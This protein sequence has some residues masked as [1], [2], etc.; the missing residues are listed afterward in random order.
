L[1]Y[2]RLLVEYDELDAELQELDEVWSV[3]KRILT[4]RPP[5]REIDVARMKEELDVLHRR[6]HDILSRQADL[7][8]RLL[9]RPQTSE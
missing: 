7:E 1:V 2:K 5:S 9:E 3:A 8:H 4:G 6:Q